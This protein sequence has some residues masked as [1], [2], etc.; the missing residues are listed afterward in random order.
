MSLDITTTTALLTSMRLSREHGDSDDASVAQV[1]DAL[2]LGFLAGRLARRPRSR[3][4]ADPT[5]FVMDHDL[6]VR[7][8]E[9]ESIL[10][11]P[12]FE[13]GLFVGRQLPDITEMPL[14]VRSL[15]VEHYTAALGG[16]RSRFDFSSYGHAYSVDAIPVVAESGAVDSVLAVAVPVDSYVAA[17]TAYE[18]T[19]ERMDA[20]AVGAGQRAALH[21]RAERAEAEAAELHTAAKAR[22]AAERARSNARRLRAR[23]AERGSEGPSITPRETEVLAL[24]SHGLTSAEIGDQLS[25]SAGTIKTHLEHIYAKLG[26]GDKVAAV[27]LAMRHR[28]ID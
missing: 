11:L 10:R 8:A 6:L 5:A 22:K 3:V 16:E 25:V 7:R 23:A 13:E 4:P 20:C 24:A 2:A 9:G 18:R 28:I 12:W 14:P 27:A 15:C 17:A 1:G 21:A 26:V 19:A